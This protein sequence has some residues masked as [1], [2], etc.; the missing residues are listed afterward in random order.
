MCSDN[1]VD[2][3]GH[4]EFPKLAPMITALE[5][6]GLLDNGVLS[7]IKLDAWDP[8]ESPDSSFRI[9]RRASSK[10]GLWS[11]KLQSGDSLP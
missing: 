6:P 8:G 1:E 2:K 9:S 3:A 7:K 10:S 11:C 4:D 5:K